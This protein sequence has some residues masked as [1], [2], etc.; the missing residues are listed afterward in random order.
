VKPLRK[1]LSLFGVLVLAT[2]TLAQPAPAPTPPSTDPAPAVGTPDPQRPQ[3]SVVEMTAQVD[4]LIKQARDD[5][6]AVEGYQAKANKEKDVVKRNCVN[7]KALVIKAQLNVI[8]KNKT[9][10]DATA[11]VEKVK[12]F[13]LISDAAND[14]RI[15]R[16][17]AAL[18]A[19]V[20]DF[21]DG[22]DGSYTGPDIPDDPNQDLFPGGV[23]DPGY[24][25]PYF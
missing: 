25:S 21:M 11:D 9:D 3:L 13:G 20:T 2:N 14:V 15:N 8:D 7:D 12:P 17:Q 1:K 22:P 4:V 10:F 6:K 24:A 16:E 5:Q 18:C 19:G 23:E